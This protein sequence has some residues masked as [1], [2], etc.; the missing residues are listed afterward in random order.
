LGQKFDSSDEDAFLLV[1]NQKLQDHIAKKYMAE[2]RI[3]ELYERN[4]E[5]E[6]QLMFPEA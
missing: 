1:L 4:T 5:L 2:Q 6:Y 3:E